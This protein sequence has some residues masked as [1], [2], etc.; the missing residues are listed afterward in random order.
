MKMR[1]VENNAFFSV[2]FNFSSQLLSTDD[3]NSHPQCTFSLHSPG[4]VPEF[5]P[6]RKEHG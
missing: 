2:L 5:S 1:V 4:S 3:F 6:V